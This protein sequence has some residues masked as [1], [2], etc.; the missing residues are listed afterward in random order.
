MNEHHPLWADKWS[1]MQRWWSVRCGV[2]GILILTGLPALSDQ[3]PNIAPTL[4]QWFPKHGEQWVPIL[5]AGI[6]ILARIVSQEYIAAMVRKA[7]KVNGD[8]Q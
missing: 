6:A 4:I 1:V 2:I 5:G 8:A 3:F 7:F